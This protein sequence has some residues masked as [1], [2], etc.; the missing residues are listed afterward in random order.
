VFRKILVPLDGSK[1]A[2][3]A[4][5]WAK[6]YA[7]PFGTPVILVQVLP[8]IYPLKGMP[9]GA[10]R[11]EAKG[12][13]TGLQHLLSQDG[14]PSEV[15]LPDNSVAESI[16]STA[17]DRNCN[18]II[19]T[20]RGSSKV[21]RWLIGGVT[22]R[23]LRLSPVPLLVL[24]NRS[25]LDPSPR[26]ILVPMD[27]SSRAKRILPW[28]E[29]LALFHDAPL[30]ILHVRSEASHRARRTSSSRREIGPTLSHWC[31]LLRRRGV[32]ATYRLSQGDPA[33]EILADSSPTDLI[34][35]TTGGT[36]GLKHYVLGSVV[37]KVIHGT[38]APVFVFR[39]LS[40]A[41]RLP[42]VRKRSAGSS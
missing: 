35:M 6:T 12:Y 23:V 5:P 9:F 28:A 13:L 39:K 11:R 42:L 1:N 3:R 10:R 21:V 24:R 26:R 15:L 30:Q 37:E 18:L 19:M 36:G 17:R 31:S 33:Q 40:K 27:G 8:K 2:E 34:V 32:N 16:V 4:L 38:Q 25:P 41:A 20:T 7:S 14:I 29:R 22:E